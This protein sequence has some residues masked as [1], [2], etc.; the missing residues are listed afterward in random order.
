MGAILRLAFFCGFHAVSHEQRLLLANEWNYPIQV[1]RGCPSIPSDETKPALMIPI[2]PIRYFSYTQ[3]LLRSWPFWI[4]VWAVFVLLGA[5]L[6]SSY[7]WDWLSTGDSGSAVVRNVILGVLAAIALPLAL[8]R[9]SV[10]ANQLVTAQRSLL[11]ERYQ[12]GAEMLNGTTLSARLGGIYTLQ[13][14]AQRYPSTYHVQVMRLFCAYFREQISL[15]RPLGDQES[16]EEMNKR[17]ALLL[18]HQ[19]PERIIVDEHADGFYWKLAEDEQTIFDAF[20]FRNSLQLKAE[21]N[22]GYLL[23]LTHLN[24]RGV[25]LHQGKF[26]NMDLSDTDMSESSLWGS[27]FHRTNFRNTKLDRAR[28]GGSVFIAPKDHSNQIVSAPLRL[29]D[30]DLFDV[31]LNNAYLFGA[32]LMNAQLKYT[33]LKNAH[34]ANANLTGAN[35]EDTNISGARFSEK[36]ARLQHAAIGLTQQQLDQTSR[37]VDKAPFVDG[38]LDA[39]TDKPLVWHGKVRGDT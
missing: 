12:K 29:T 19:T 26:I 1:Q 20:N 24:L 30:A 35:F 36:P 28:L 2:N 10:A 14:L 25:D 3:P 34:L 17:E 37:N 18:P 21:E 6:A 31:S 39:E 32:Q 11:G 27:T 9:S 33:S 8:W 13:Q 22:E 5:G 16:A 7:Y 15:R 38:V 4:L 23:N